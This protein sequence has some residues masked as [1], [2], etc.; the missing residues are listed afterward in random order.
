MTIPY[1]MEIMGETLTG[2]LEHHLE[3]GTLFFLPNPG[4]ASKIPPRSLWVFASNEVTIDNDIWITE[5]VQLETLWNNIPPKKTRHNFT[6]TT[7]IFLVALK[8]MSLHHFGG[9]DVLED[10]FGG[11]HFPIQGPIHWSQQKNPEIQGTSHPH[12]VIP[13]CFLAHKQNWKHAI[14]LVGGWTTHLK[15]MLVKLESSSPNRGENKKYLKPRP[16]EVKY[17]FGS[18]YGET[19]T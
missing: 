15:N 19:T 17:F 6:N 10:F 3:I 4:L 2:D 8:G 18:G 9:P 1:Y 11:E 7:W 14:F 12:Q 13:W 5:F 16:S